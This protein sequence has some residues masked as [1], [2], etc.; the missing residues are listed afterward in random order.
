M[1]YRKNH[2]SE[3]EKQT[4]VEIGASDIFKKLAHLDELMEKLHAEEMNIREQLHKT[5]QD[6]KNQVEHIE[7]KQKKMQSLL[8]TYVNYD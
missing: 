5:C 6:L 7:T 2:N 8:K 1:E 4:T 3:S